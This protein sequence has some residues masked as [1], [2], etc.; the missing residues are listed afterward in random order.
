MDS[1]ELVITSFLSSETRGNPN[2]VG[3]KDEIIADRNSFTRYSLSASD[4]S[5]YMQLNY[6][7]RHS[8]TGTKKTPNQNP[9]TLLTA[10]D[11]NLLYIYD[12]HVLPHILDFATHFRGLYVVRWKNVLSLIN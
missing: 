8:A 1:E 3:V 12:T 4:R 5:R 9:T 6:H 2:S 11:S 7:L 10:S